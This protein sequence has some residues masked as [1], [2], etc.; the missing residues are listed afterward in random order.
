MIRNVSKY[1]KVLALLIIVTIVFFSFPSF[2]NAHNH[3]DH[4]HDHEHHHHE[5]PP[6]FKYSKEA[7]AK[8][9]QPT[10]KKKAMSMSSI[11]SEA[12]SSTII[13]SI[14]PF[15][16]LYF[17]PLNNRREH[18][19]F[20]KILLSFASGGLLGDA[21]LHLIPHALMPHS[22]HD[23][24]CHS[25]SH[26]HSHSHGDNN[27]GLWVL[28]GI[29][30]FL[31]IEKSVR[32][33]KGEHSH[34]HFDSDESEE[35]KDKSDKKKKAV[36]EKKSDDKVA[37]DDKDSASETEEEIKVAGYLNLAADFTHNFTDGLA[38]GASY[39]AGRTV[40]WVTTITIL[41]HEIPHEIGD[42]AILVQSGCSKKKAMFLQLITAVGAITG[43]VVSLLSGGID[44]STTSWVLPFTAGGFIYIAT[45][46]I[47][48]DLLTDT[49]FVQSIKEIAALLFGVLM[50]V[51]VAQFE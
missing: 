9:Q 10:S 23:G 45:V 44:E 43:T 33:L 18:S 2:C 11:W 8:S 47:I 21:F 20:L 38:I 26:S 46:S 49:K 7:N 35:H 37:D 3:H 48:P 34:S 39:L 6:S 12:L 42:F 24:H 25:H 22:H 32:L 50:M 36:K 5:E 30:A 31:V 29:L 17:I 51:I 16:I 28:S 27:I 40:G 15:I 19:S 14:A 41:F 4:D 1:F 13:I